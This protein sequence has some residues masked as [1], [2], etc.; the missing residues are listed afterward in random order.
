MQHKNLLRNLFFLRG[1]STKFHPLLNQNR[2]EP[3]R[4]RYSNANHPCS[5]Y[6]LPGFHFSSP[7]LSPRHSHTRRTAARATWRPPRRPQPASPA[8]RRPRAPPPPPR[9]A[10]SSRRSTGGRRRRTGAARRC[11][12]PSSPR[13]RRGGGRQGSPTPP[14]P[15]GRA[16]TTSPLRLWHF[17][18]SWFRSLLPLVVPVRPRA[19]VW[20]RCVW[21]DD[22]IWVR[23]WAALGFENLDVAVCVVDVAGSV[24]V[25]EV[26]TPWKHIYI[27]RL[28]FKFCYVVERVWNWLGQVNAVFFR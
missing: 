13:R 18:P 25:V 23:A 20:I 21:C 28:S 1:V 8:S 7:L 14:P 15:P 2:R 16:S 19:L 11:L 26:G 27:D 9:A 4:R 10:S 6:S 22:G 3:I 5:L 24:V 12:S 17:E